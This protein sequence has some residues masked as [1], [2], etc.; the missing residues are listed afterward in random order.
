M[1]RVTARHRR[2]GGRATPLAVAL[3]ALVVVV[4]LTAT[5]LIATALTSG[6]SHGAHRRPVVVAPAG[7]GRPLTAGPTEATPATGPGTTP[8]PAAVVTA[9]PGPTTSTIDPGLLPQTRDLPSGTDPAFTARINGLWQAIV[10]GNPLAALPAFFPL[11]AYV[12]VKVLPNP[13]ADWRYRL[14]T[15]YRSD[16][17]ALHRALGSS[18]PT[19]RLLSVTVP[20]GRAV[21][22]NPGVEGNRIGYWRVY[23][24]VVT[25]DNGGI[26]HTFTILSLISWRGQ[27]YVV[28]LSHIR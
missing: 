8:A 6:G 17:D 11:T 10:T 1:H 3:A 15:G 27:W 18:A 23:D 19:A 7:V 22:I 28:H 25:Y 21:W 20:A 12:Q 26:T 14:I 5:A 16:I 24:T 9:T 4:A 2:R 13:A